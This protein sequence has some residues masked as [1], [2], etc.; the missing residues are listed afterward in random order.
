MADLYSSTEFPSSPFCEELQ[1]RIL[2]LHKII[3]VY[4]QEENRAQK[5]I[6]QA[7]DYLRN[8]PIYTQ[9]MEMHFGVW[10]NTSGIHAWASPKS[11]GLPRE[12]NKPEYLDANPEATQNPLVA[13][14]WLMDFQ[15][16]ILVV[17]KD[18]HLPLLNNILPGR[19]LK[20]FLANEQQIKKQNPPAKIIIIT[21]PV[22][23]I[24]IELEKD[25]CVLDFALPSESVISSRLEEIIETVEQARLAEGSDKWKIDLSSTKKEEIV[26]QSKGLTLIEFED[27]AARGIIEKGKPDAEIVKEQKKQIVI[28]NQILEPIDAIPMSQVG[29]LDRLKD[30]LSERSHA[31]TKKGRDYGLKTPKGILLLGIQ[32]CGKSWVSRAVAHEWNLPLYSFDAARVFN[33]AVGSSESN[34]R[35]ALKTI[36]ALSPCCLFMDE[37]DKTLSG[38]GSSNF[39]DAG[40]TSRVFG[41]LLTWMNDHK[42]EVFVVATANSVE[43]LPPE[44]LRKGRVDLIA[45][46]DL[47]AIKA[48]QDIFKIHISKINRNPSDYNIEKLAK[49]TEHFS[50]AEIQSVIE[51]ALV[52]SFKD[53]LLKDRHIVQTIEQTIPLWE[54]RKE[55]IQKLI[56]WVGRD[57]K[58][59]EGIRAAYASSESFNENYNND[60][61]VVS[62]KIEDQDS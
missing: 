8:R 7:V 57:E 9:P 11:V 10:T 54:T 46:V 59:K 62:L 20:D 32:G 37:I 42:H 45:F 23:D 41:T 40:V 33:A 43:N 48:R 13:I 39:S 31:W 16:D 14:Q 36:E 6:A 34:T 12:R 38:V 52:K 61:N 29:G 1:K 2:S 24:P 22:L 50:G 53:G 15:K 4:T 5:E 26:K 3:W 27:A 49:M 60:E 56:D 30:W 47:P 55:E 28:K 21:A 51:T 25:V 44:L 35:S 58:K 19:K 18:L 17:F